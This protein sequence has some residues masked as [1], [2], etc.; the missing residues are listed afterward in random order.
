[1]SASRGT[2]RHT[3][4]R[5]RERGVVVP[6]FAHT[7]AE[8]LGEMQIAV[9]DGS[10]REKCKGRDVLRAFC[11][12]HDFNYEHFRNLLMS[13]LTAPP[14]GLDAIMK[15]PWLQHFRF[16]TCRERRRGREKSH[17]GAAGKK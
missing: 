15:Q 1:M 3:Y 10:W 16:P 13:K 9:A 14:P 5:A 17:L 8:A 11:S 4:A 2:K 6:T 7:G 12:A